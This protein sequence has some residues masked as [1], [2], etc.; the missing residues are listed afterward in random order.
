MKKERSFSG[1]ML[2]KKGDKLG[3]FLEGHI[4]PPLY[5]GVFVPEIFGWVRVCRNGEWGYI[6]I[7]GDYTADA[8]EAYLSYSVS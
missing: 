6:D 7:N 3:V 2:I 1:E 8:N 4:V 5:D